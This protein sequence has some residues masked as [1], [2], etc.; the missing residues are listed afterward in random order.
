L[1][2]GRRL[3]STAFVILCVAAAAA[4]ASARSHVLLGVLGD[5]ARFQQQTG[6]VSETRLRIVG[7]GQGATYGSPLAAL[8]PTMGS[9]PMLG[10]STT[11]QSGG[12]I[13][14]RQ[15]ALGQGDSY[16]VAVNHAI[17]AFGKPVL[18]RPYAEMNGHWNPYSAYNENGSARNSSHTTALFRAAFARTYL[19]AHG[20][21]K[22]GPVLA[23]LGQPA[24]RGSLESNTNVQ[25]IWNPQGAGSPDLPGNSAAAYYPG[26]SY[27]DIVGDDLYDIGY[28]ADWP[29]AQALYDAHPAKPFAIPE[30]AP[31]GIDDPAFVARMASFVQAHPRTMLVSY[32]SGT[33]GSVFDLATKPKSRAAY[34][35]LIVPLGR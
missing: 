14:P 27:V 26:D 35:R 33:P 15:I 17:H 8:L 13:T 19:I 4:G 34:R 22:V 30:W 5:P 10:L 28:R 3:L 24:V 21:A 12:E 25:V 2:V 11:L 18:L 20:G 7:W 23:K 6:Q 32:Y 1:P 31:W 9:E 16:L 29:D